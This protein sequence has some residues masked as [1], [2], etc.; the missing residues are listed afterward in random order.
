MTDWRR[1]RWGVEWWRVHLPPLCT[2]P[3]CLP[4][5]VDDTFPDEN[6][7]LIDQLCEKYPSMA[8]LE[9]ETFHLCV[10]PLQH[11]DR[12]FF[13]LWLCATILSAVTLYTFMSPWASVQTDACANAGT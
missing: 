2:L 8:T 12:H 5:R 7:H 10:A 13:L 6:E 11:R 1:D 3:E 9:M 4:G